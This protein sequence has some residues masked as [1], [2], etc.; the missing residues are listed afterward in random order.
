MRRGRQG[1]VP[2]GVFLCVALSMSAASARRQDAAATGL[3]AAG[4]SASGLVEGSNETV[5]MYLLAA[6]V[7]W[8]AA[9]ANRIWTR[10]SSWCATICGPEREPS[11]SLKPEQPRLTSLLPHFMATDGWCGRRYDCMCDGEVVHRRPNASS[12]GE[13]DRIEMLEAAETDSH[14]GSV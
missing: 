4:R 9:V 6:S 13:E 5:P 12:E 14:S 7:I 1:R 10:C 2:A 3:V 8:K 11:L